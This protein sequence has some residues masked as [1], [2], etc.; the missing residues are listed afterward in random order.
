MA[1]GVGEQGDPFGGGA[2]RDAVAGQAGADAER[3]RQVGLAG[4]GRAEQDDVLAAGEEVELAEVQ[5]RVA[6][7]RGLEG[8]VE[9]LE[10]LAGGEARGLD[11]G[12]AAVAVAAVDLGLQ[13]RGGELL[14]APLLGAGAVGELGQRPRRGRRLERAEQVR[15]LGASGGSCDQRV[16]GGQRAD[17]DDRLAWPRRSA[18]WALSARACSSAVIVRCRANDARVPAGELAGVQ[19]DRE[20][21]ALGDAGLDAAADQPRV[22]RVVA[23][24]EAQI[25]VRRDPQH[26]APV[27]VGRASPAAAPSPARSSTSR[28]IGRQRSVL[29]IRGL[30]RSSNQASSWSWKSSSLANAPAGLEA[31]SRRSPAGARRRPWPADRAGS[32]KCQPTRSCAAERGERLGRAAA[33]GVQPGLAI[34][35]QRLAAAPPSDHRQRRIPNSRSGVCLEK[36]SAPAPARE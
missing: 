32:Q 15:E 13:Q 19:R 3:D 26:P 9:L 11:P 23:G 27:G 25:G 36:I 17:L 20:D 31:A 18:R 12:L 8:E 30:A 7:E 14:I 6:A 1:L 29:C 5:H 28:S 4:A 35:D 24:V 16:I 22:E 34:P 33:A 21:L 2:E 10:R